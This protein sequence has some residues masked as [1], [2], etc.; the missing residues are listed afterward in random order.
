MGISF[1]NFSGGTSSS[2]NGFS[3]LVGDT[4]NT[5]YSF[6]TAQPAGSYSINSKLGDTTFDVYLISSNNSNVGYTNSTS[7]EATDKFTKIVLYGAT[8]N[9]VINFEYK[10]SASPT[11]LGDVEDGAAPFLT[12]ATPTT[13]ASIDDTTTVTGGNFA[14]D[15][16]V[17]FTG[18][19]AVDRAA[20]N[21]VRSDSTSLIVTRPDDFPVEQEPYSMTATNAGITNPSLNINKIT[22]YFDAGSGIIWSTSSILPSAILNVSYSTTLE[23]T[24]ADGGAVTYSFSSGSLPTGL[25]F[26]P[27]TPEISGTPAGSGSSTFNI[28]AT[29][30]GGNSSSRE[31]TLSVANPQVEYIVI[32]GG[33]A[34]GGAY[35]GGGGAGGYRSSIAGELSGG[36]TSAESPFAIALSTNY[37][38]TVGNGGAPTV[39]GY[40]VGNAGNGGASVFATITS[41]GGGGGGNA[42]IGSAGGSGGGGMDNFAGG[43]G[44]SNQGSSGGAGS[45]GVNY[46]SGGGGGAGGAGTNGTTSAGGSGGIGIPSS[47]TGSTIYRAGGGG[48]GTYR[49]GTAGQGGQGGGADAG[50]SGNYPNN[51]NSG[52]PNTGG[53]GGGASANPYVTVGG[54]GGSGA[55]ILKYSNAFEIVTGPGLTSYTLTDG[56][57]KVTTFTSGSDSIQ[58]QAATVQ[59]TEIEFLVIAG[60]GGGG[61]GFG[62]GG[63]AGGYLSSVSGEQ[64]GGGT[65]S[66]FALAATDNTN[67]PVSVGAGGT[68]STGTYPSNTAGGTGINSS[69]SLITSFGGGGGGSHNTANFGRVGGSG[70]AGSLAIP[71]NGYPGSGIDGQGFDAGSHPSYTPEN[72]YSD[73]GGG[74][75]SAGGAGSIV[76]TWQSVSGAGGAGVVSSITGSVI[77][78]AGGGGGGGGGRT[79]GT[80]GSATGGGGTG[81]SGSSD[82]ATSTGASGTI[83]SGG[84]GGGQYRA[85]SGTGSSGGSGVIILRYPATKTLTVG[86]GLTADPAIT[87]GDK[88]IT[89]IKSGTDTVSIS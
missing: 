18:Q 47:V 14:A 29:D 60:G 83:N 79:T 38:V 81:G 74:A 23:A 6:T 26:N 27:S 8:T 53:G 13:L 36:G 58:F 62:G 12:S 76:G 82:S 3:L 66:M 72:E 22:D 77:E 39:S 73:G 16:E 30:S 48:G 84:G 2:S 86:A 7:L 49:G 85:F 44:T 45:S 5:T 80:G 54:S 32:G 33:G 19:D 61:G 46:G 10:P 88:K 43:A 31:F 59:T 87:V 63:G 41:D 67:Y 70:G 50:S 64:S 11:S 51:G 28:L 21:I 71:A 52:V 24:D 55:V 65:S 17:V 78:R 68:P 4:G 25:S 37:T 69:F 42:A 40:A 9:D 57:N 75:G 20:K 15:V 89:V 35:G 56:T 1:S 34:G